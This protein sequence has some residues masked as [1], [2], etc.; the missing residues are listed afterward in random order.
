MNIVA[1]DSEHL[2][3]T[4]EEGGDIEDDIKYG[5]GIYSKRCGNVFENRGFDWMPHQID[6][7][8]FF[9]EEKKTKFKPQKGLLLFHKLGSG[10]TC[11]AISIADSMLGKPSMNIDS[12]FIMTEGS[13][14]TVWLEEYCNKCGLN[15]GTINN[16]VKFITYNYNLSKK[17]LEKLDFS[18]SLII[19]D[20]VHNFIR[21][22]RNWK[23]NKTVVLLY[24]KIM[25]CSSCRILALS[26]TPIARYDYEFGLLGNLLQ[27]GSFPDM[28][29]ERHER[30]NPEK[31][32][33]YVDKKELTDGHFTY[34]IK[35]PGEN[36]QRFQN[37]I[38]FH[39]GSQS[40]LPRVIINQPVEVKMS[41]KQS[42]MYWR[43]L[44]LEKKLIGMDEENG[45][46]GAYEAKERK[47]LRNVIIA[48][49][50][51]K[52]SLAASNAYYDD[53]VFQIDKKLES[54][55]GIKSEI[56]KKM[57]SYEKQREK[58]YQKREQD[59]LTNFRRILEEARKQLNEN[60]SELDLLKHP[61]IVAFFDEHFPKFFK[62]CENIFNLPGKHVV[63]SQFVNVSGLL[64]LLELL[65]A[66]DIDTRMFYGAMSQEKR[67]KALIDFND[68][69][70]LNGSEVK[71]L[72]LSEAGS[73]GLSFKA[74]RHMHILES[75]TEFVTLMQAIGRV[76]RHKSH[77]KLEEKD[78][79]VTI[80]RYH[81]IP[82]DD[83]KHVGK[84]VITSGVR[85]EKQYKHISKRKREEE[86]IVLDESEFRRPAP[87]VLKK[88]V[89]P[90]SPVSSAIS[91]RRSLPRTQSD[92][93]III[94]DKIERDTGSEAY[95]KTR[96]NE[97]NSAIISDADR[98]DFSNFD[99][100]MKELEDLKAKL[101]T[102]ESKPAPS[103]VDSLKKQITE[104]ERKRD[105]DLKK[106]I[107]SNLDEYDVMLT[108]L[109]EELQKKQGQVKF[110]FLTYNRNY[111]IDVSL[112]EKELRDLTTYKEFCNFI[113]SFSVTSPQIPLHQRR[114]VVYMEID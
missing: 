97:I 92:E 52:M 109:R 16:K 5:S 51:R 66:F 7:R 2:R 81:G 105:T 74:V 62:I 104:I 4:D 45:G 11:L 86:V 106:G 41:P 49:R 22:V 37:I 35:N 85:S 47:R 110:R 63:F 59:L 27:P 64:L 53:A 61:L 69:N 96:I 67:S 108:S 98:Q 94:D 113:S 48:A 56:E 102:V 78:R 25:K 88:Y 79:N 6:V 101:Q 103:N 31:F 57:D 20:E 50:K 29:D 26:G 112:Y 77:E 17:M 65:K 12:V 107:Y 33:Q 44:D 36:L 38:S 21:G 75:N 46:S 14:R 100:Y 80:H 39:E 99:K 111:S 91:I 54:K 70:N 34:K 8:N 43:Q 58:F 28:I 15:S 42:N 32:L 24:N 3:L 23:K 90:V 82:V 87:P 89:P 114:D 55:E 93:V 76:A 40:D 60:A 95:I 72:L 84:L 30:V 1:P 73:T 71:V 18:R 9:L 10:K 19:I 68:S 13:L 83:G